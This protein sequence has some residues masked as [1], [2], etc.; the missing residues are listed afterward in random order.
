MLYR[1]QELWN[2]V[3]DKILRQF[4]HVPEKKK[5][6]V[7]GLSHKG[8]YCAE[9]P[10]HQGSFAIVWRQSERMDPQTKGLKDPWIV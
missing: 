3:Y 2:S 7:Y 5:A 9:T 6:I 1:M 4:F 8:Q 10:L